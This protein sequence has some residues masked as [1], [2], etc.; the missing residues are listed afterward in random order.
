MKAKIQRDYERVLKTL[1]VAEKIKNNGGTT[2]IVMAKKKLDKIKKLDPSFDTSTADKIVTAFEA[3]TFDY[4]SWR[5]M[6]KRILRYYDESHVVNIDAMFFNSK[7]LKDAQDFDLEYVKEI[8]AERKAKNTLDS[9]DKETEKAIN[10][11]VNFIRAI[12]LP[13]AFLKRLDRATG[14]GDVRNPVVTLQKARV[15]KA[16]AEAIFRFTGPDNPNMRDVV[17]TAD[18][19]IQNAESTL[20]SVYTSEFHKKHLGEIVFSKKPLKIGSEKESDITTK[21]K[22]G[23]AIY[24]TVYLGRTIGTMIGDD[25]F[26]KIGA[27]GFSMNFSDNARPAHNEKWE[28]SFAFLRSIS[29]SVNHLKDTYIQF[30]LIPESPSILKDPRYEYIKRKNYSP[31]IF[32]RG[33]QAKSK[34][35]LPISLHFNT[36]DRSGFIQKFEGKFEIDLSYGEGPDYYREIENRLIDKYIEDNEIP[37]PI[38][39]DPALEAQLLSHMND[40]GWR[41]TFVKAVISTEWMEEILPGGKKQ[42]IIGAFMV[43]KHPD[44]Y[45]FY[46]QYDFVAFPSGDGWTKPQY[47]ASGERTRVLCSKIR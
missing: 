15:V 12:D 20:E 14:R 9:T 39:R 32:V 44:G 8:L 45:C 18:R 10:D 16:E 21:F 5:L 7:L 46:H 47:H 35:N 31:V 11:Y 30:I 2:D 6:R 40:K 4:E 28:T 27:T 26:N 42:R 23:D 34:R 37:Q 41:E 43:A 1:T 36:G 13:N 29:V 19:S 38:R 24:G 33:L 17:A 25:A 22:T 3:N